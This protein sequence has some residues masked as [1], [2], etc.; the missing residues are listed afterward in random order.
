M[1]ILANFGKKTESAFQKHSTLR[2]VD[3]V[4]KRNAERTLNI[5]LTIK[6]TLK[7]HLLF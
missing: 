1:M 2:V 7:W 6:K 4:M 5:S 3:L